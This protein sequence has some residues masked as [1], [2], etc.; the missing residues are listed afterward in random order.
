MSERSRLLAPENNQGSDSEMDVPTT[1]NDRAP[2]VCEWLYLFA[3][4]FLQHKLPSFYAYPG[5]INL[6]IHKVDSVDVAMLEVSS[7]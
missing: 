4:E 1:E 2:M 5:T 3:P 7:L 6:I